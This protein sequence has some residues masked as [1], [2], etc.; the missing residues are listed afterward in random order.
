MID[1]SSYNPPQ[2]L[3][4][5][6]G[7]GPLLILAGA[8][9]GKTRVLTGR[10][11]R[12]VDEG[13]PPYRILAIT[14]TNKAAAEMKER[15]A[16]LCGEKARDAW[17]MTFHAMCA[18]MLR[19]DI[20][21]LG[22]TNAFTIYDAD[23]QASLVKECLK[24]LNLSDKEY[25]PSAVRAVISDAKNKLLSPQEWFSASPRGYREQKYLDI[26]KLYEERLR[27]QNALDFDDL[28]VRTLELFLEHP[29]VLA[30]YQ[31]KF[32]YVMV[33]EYQDTNHAQYELT[34]LLAGQKRNLCVVG[35]DDQSIYGWRGADIRNI[36]DFERDN[37]DAAVIKLEQNY[38]ST[39]VILDAAN[40]VIRHNEGRKDKRLW[41][42]RDG[43]APIL[44]RQV[45]NEHEEAERFLRDAKRL[46]AEGVPYGDMA[47]LYRMNTQSRVLEEALVRGGVPHRMVGGFRFYERAEVRDLIAYLRVL[48]NP[49]DDQCLLRVINTPRRG[50][51]DTTVA[52]LREASLNQGANMLDIVLGG[53]AD[54]LPPRAQA[55]VAAFSDLMARLFA[56]KEVMTPSELL[57]AVIEETRY[58]AALQAGKDEDAQERLDNIDELAGAVSEYE[59]SSEQPTLA[60]FLEHVAL[61]S[62]IDALRETG[63]AVTLMTLHSAK[64]LEFP[65][66]WM[67]GLEEGV[68]PHSR[69]LV[70][71]AQ[72][73]EE[74]RLCYVGITRAMDR[75]ILSSAQCRTLQGRTT[76]QQPS[77]FLSEIPE[78]LIAREGGS[79]REQRFQ[80]R[81][82]DEES[83]WED[84]QNVRPR[85][86]FPSPRP[87]T[88]PA[89]GAG[90]P[91]FGRPA[92]F[93][94]SIARAE[95]PAVAWQAGD[96]VKHDVFGMG[97]VIRVGGPSGA[98]TLDVLF[99]GVGSKTLAAAIAPLHKA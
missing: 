35:D 63:G 12:L 99:A 92:A 22:Y 76:L 15:V 66:V 69:A 93:V 37:P 32:D 65:C 25:V 52:V 44:V 82:R 87:G 33:D 41:T 55:A 43:G 78:H 86:G 23:D 89:A 29:P 88:G 84:E 14:F 39:S 70:D 77:R 20:E 81:R 21:K 34:R 68:F 10:I 50:I 53:G 64:G 61:V 73:E 5:L 62:D 18:R 19:R 28:L 16:L 75:L 94:P 2:R 1:L 4:V 47:A 40:G 60:G 54:A 6:H 58:R 74:R 96:K 67:M 97:V 45:Q 27:K 80:P 98:Q 95:K 71:D 24:H 8:G 91:G 9:S 11:A 30:Y 57:K 3:A 90:R 56:C 17:I 85:S 7:D 48:E 31:D 83:T 79:G 51:G 72:M 49:A 36:L 13:V 42:Q 59:A 46:A 38:R 26:Y